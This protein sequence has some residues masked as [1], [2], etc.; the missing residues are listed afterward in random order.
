MLRYLKAEGSDPPPPPRRPDGWFDA[1]DLGVWLRRHHTRRR[2]P[3]RGE[4]YPYAPPG[5]FP[6]SM[7]QSGGNDGSAETKNEIEIRLKTAQ[8]IKLETEQAITDGRLIEADR[9]ESAWTILVQRVRSRL[10]R[11]P[12]ALAM[13]VARDTDPNSVQVTLDDA[14]RDVLTELSGDWRDSEPDEGDDDAE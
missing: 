12:S 8:A 5:W 7:Q 13:V 11:M 10:L 2:G 9:I 6:A 1:E 4:N 3:G 14:V